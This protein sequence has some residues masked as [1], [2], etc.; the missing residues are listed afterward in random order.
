MLAG[1][2]CANHHRVHPSSDAGLISRTDSRRP[3]KRARSD[4]DGN[5]VVN[6]PPPALVI[7]L[8]EPDARF[9]ETN[10]DW[11]NA[12]WLRRKLSA[13]VGASF[14]L[15]GDAIAGLA[16]FKAKSHDT[17]R[18]FVGTWNMYGRPPPPDISPCIPALGLSAASGLPYHLLSITTQECSRL[19]E[20]SVL[21]PDKSAWELLLRSHLGQAY[22]MLC[23]CTMAG[24]HIVV[25]AHKSLFARIDTSSIRSVK[26]PCGI[27]NVLGNKGAVAVSLEI[28]GRTL[29]FVG[30]HLT[31]GDKPKYCE[32]RNSDHRR[33]ETLL[34]EQ[35][36]VG[37][38]LPDL[39]FFAGD[40]NYRVNATREEADEWID[41][42]KVVVLWE[43]DQLTR[44]MAQGNALKD[45][46]EAGPVAFP[47]THKYNVATGVNEILQSDPAD[48]DEDDSGTSPPSPNTPLPGT[49][50][51][52]LSMPSSYARIP[53]DARPSMQYDSSKK[54]RVPAWTDRVLLAE[55]STLSKSQSS[56][57]H[58]L[59]NHHPD[60]HHP[61]PRP[62]SAHTIYSKSR[63][64]TPGS[65]RGG[66][67]GWLATLLV[68]R[69]EEERVEC[70][71]YRAVGELYGSDHR[72]VIAVFEVSGWE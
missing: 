39:T 32:A 70:K 53:P 44:E 31:A 18:I 49:N 46:K 22:T 38:R 57:P 58:T 69:K 8:P 15:L 68:W 4:E 30:V 54:R 24:L 1:C 9:H 23:A 34:A 7:D 71:E 47:P 33:I 37:G 66:A 16:G 11:D 17:I 27:A 50:F 3:L 10:E 28:G 60:L 64:T 2:C 14:V 67:P 20:R 5:E 42:G 59:S 61:P 41:T 63:P 48:E 51:P 6:A 40:L 65:S 52:A 43:R 12:P 26:V 72:P 21:F 56:L 62:K 29:C 25:F 19:L 55:S 45:Y 13:T 36:Y 35:L